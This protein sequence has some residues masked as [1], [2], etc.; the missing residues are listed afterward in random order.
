MK[1]SAC[2]F[3]STSRYSLYLRYEENVP[4]GDAVNR[5]QNPALRRKDRVTPDGANDRAGLLLA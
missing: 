4:F 3:V 2:F 5:D 1:R